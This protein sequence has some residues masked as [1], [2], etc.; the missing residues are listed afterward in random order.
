MIRFE[1]RPR[2]K[3]HLAT[4]SRNTWKEMPNEGKYGAF[5]GT[6]SFHTLNVK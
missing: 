2:V 1:E 4:D 5:S 6:Y 3:K